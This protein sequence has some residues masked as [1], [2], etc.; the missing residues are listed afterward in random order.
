M[1]FDRFSFGRLASDRRGTIAVILALGALPL[2]LAMG[3]AV[4]YGR[5][6]NAEQ[7]LQAAS[8]SVA[9]M[10]AKDI[11]AGAR[12]D[13]VAERLDRYFA[14][15]VQPNGPLTDL[16]PTFAYDPATYTV[17][18]DATGS[19]PT[20]FMAL[21]GVEVMRIRAGSTVVNGSDYLEIALALDNTGSMASNRKLTE[22]K[23]AANTM[24]EDIARTP[25]GRDGR[26]SIAIVPFGVTVNV[27]TNNVNAP[28]LGPV[29]TERVCTGNGRNRTC[30]D[31]ETAWTGCIGDR[32]QPFTVGNGHANTAAAKYPRKSE[33]CR[34]APILSL[35]TDFDD[36]GDRIDDMV[37]TGNTNI[38]ISL[39]WAWNMLTPG[40]PLSNARVPTE[41]ERVMRYLILLTD[42]QNT[43]NTLGSSRVQIDTITE[44]TCTAV[45]A[46]R[47][48]VFTIR[49]IDGN[50][51][52]LRDCAT[53]ANFYFD[54]SDP[55]ILTDVFRQ[56]MANISRLRI[57][58]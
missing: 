31:V 21:A 53:S 44:D 28:W 47:I 49:V 45:K 43:E 29:E 23:R 4:D 36:A 35:T 13:E 7:R 20:T 37:A 40:A 10:I 51:S 46:A 18:V 39:V 22:L 57:A 34:V 5:Y 14:L 15:E 11:E 42:G 41:R 52:L 26:A 55:G 12:P 6:T 19:V 2:V 30:R 1:I 38:P 17:T 24:I 27:G 16:S 50:A 32:V 25:S 3:A 33:N 48:T 54:V 58:S 56:I 9:L 8:D